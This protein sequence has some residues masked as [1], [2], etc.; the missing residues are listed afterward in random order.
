GASMQTELGLAV[1][2][3][4]AGDGLIWTTVGN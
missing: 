2:G 1:M 4:I 3:F